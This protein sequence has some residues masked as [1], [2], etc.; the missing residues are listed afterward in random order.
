MRPKNKLK[1]DD[2]SPRT[3][4][5]ATSNN[6]TQHALRPSQKS[7]AFS[8]LKT[9]LFHAISTP[10]NGQKHDSELDDTSHNSPTAPIETVRVSGVT[11]P[12]PNTLD[13][14]RTHPRPDS[15]TLLSKSFEPTPNQEWER[16]FGNS[17]NA[18]PV[19]VLGLEGVVKQIASTNGNAAR[20]SELENL[21][22]R[23][24]S[25]M[26]TPVKRP[27]TIS[28]SNQTKSKRLSAIVIKEG[29]LFKKTDFKTFS[30]TARLDRSWKGYHIVL[31]GHK[32]YLYRAQHENQLKPY[33]PSPKDNM[34]ISQSNVSFGSQSLSSD[35]FPSYY[36]LLD[37][38]MAWDY[39]DFDPDS[40]TV[41]STVCNLPVGI[42]PTLHNSEYLYG[43]CFTEV[44][45]ITGAYKGYFCLLIFKTRLL[46][47]KK[48]WP[49]TKS[50][51]LLTL[52]Y[53]QIM[54]CS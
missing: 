21:H 26:I 30:R 10:S 6:E 4:V 53:E 34:S 7:G 8:Y 37:K 15:G 50:S 27:N 31:R 19:S 52:C 44:D 13:I 46:I 3:S 17:G 23:Q 25:A 12:S 28:K 49:K 32:L 33:F 20:Q 38:G 5:D 47:C 22:A 41:I 40:Q 11:E 48:G 42:Q 16:T 29:Y 35:V 1:S 18:R 36:L 24:L 54:R 14:P 45:Q 2:G 9:R 43:D 39:N 51:T